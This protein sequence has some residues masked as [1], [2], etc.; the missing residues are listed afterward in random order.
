[1]GKRLSHQSAAESRGHRLQAPAAEGKAVTAPEHPA[2]RRGISRKTPDG[3]RRYPPQKGR[4][5]I[6]LLNLGWNRERIALPLILGQ[7]F[8]I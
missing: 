1:M 2:G 7:G 5:K 4:D 3:W 6:S 8:F